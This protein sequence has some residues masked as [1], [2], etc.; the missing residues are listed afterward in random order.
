MCISKKDTFKFLEGA[1]G[2]QNFIGLRGLWGESSTPCVTFNIYGYCTLAEKRLQWVE[3]LGWKTKWTESVWCT[4][5][6]FNAVRLPEERNGV[7]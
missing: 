1:K 5:E 4:G 6:Y 3:L 7:S 2:R